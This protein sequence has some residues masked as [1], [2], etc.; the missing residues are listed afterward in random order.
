MIFALV[1]SGLA[2]VAVAPAPPAAA[3]PSGYTQGSMVVAE[4]KSKV[5]RGDVQSPSSWFRQFDLA[6]LEE[7]DVFSATKVRFGVERAGAPRG[8]VVTVAEGP[9]LPLPSR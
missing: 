9:C 8:E 6:D 5:C 4:F 2:L 3:V 7:R 1:A